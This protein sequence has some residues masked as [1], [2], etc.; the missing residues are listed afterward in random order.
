M[1]GKC[2]AI[3]VSCMDFRLQDF[4]YDWA[5]KR[6]GQR[7]HDR[8]AWAGAAKNV[9]LTLEQVGLSKKLHNISIVVLINHEE[10]GAYGA[11]GTP[12]KQAADLKFAATKINEQNPDLTVETYYLHLD[13]TFK[14]VD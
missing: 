11:E 12:E 10:C 9:D 14:K 2:D 3:I 1:A 13:G 4:I 7:N 5:I 8:V 6:F